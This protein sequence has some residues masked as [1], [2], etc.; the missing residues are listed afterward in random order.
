MNTALVRPR[1]AWVGVCMITVAT[2]A[3]AQLAERPLRFT[4]E[5]W[6]NETWL[7]LEDRDAVGDGRLS[8]L[9]ILQRFD[10]KIDAEYELDLV[11]SAFSLIDDYWW[12]TQDNGIRYLGGSI[13]RRELYQ[14]TDVKIAVPAADDWQIRVRLNNKNS[15]TVN[16]S[17]VRAEVRKTWPSGVFGFA[18]GSLHEIKPSSDISIGA[19]VTVPSVHAKAMVVVLDAFNGVTEQLLRDSRF[20]PTTS[21]EYERHPI[22]FRVSADVQAGDRLRAEVHG[23]ILLTARVRASARAQP[24]SGFTQT[25]GFRLLGA[26]A[27]WSVK[28]HLTVGAFATHVRASL[29]RS[30]LPLGLAQDDFRLIEQT[31]RFGGVVL[32]RPTDRWVVQ[33][34][35]ARS[36]RPEQRSY[37]STGGSDVDWE[38]RAWSGQASARYTSSRFLSTVA[39]DWDLRHVLRGNPNL[40]E[41]MP[42]EQGRFVGIGQ[43]P[44]FEYLGRNQTRVRYEIGWQFDPGRRITLGFKIDLDADNYRGPNSR[45]DGAHAR[46]EL[47]W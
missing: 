19:G 36:F 41:L 37:A 45:F 28:R 11:S 6:A 44:S 25:E 35:T 32:A 29:N 2:P 3:H 40:S 22:A 31:T 21:I 10:D 26:L 5:D 30:A 15:P 12:R 14:R 20:G 47:T 46:F 8:R 34:W 33:T 7:L 38:D 9:G 18:Q 43:V 42:D 23:A 13:N 16:R 27:E 39:I 1:L 24:D 4:L 17:L